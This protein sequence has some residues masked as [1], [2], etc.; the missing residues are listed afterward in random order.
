MCGVRTLVAG[1]I[2]GILVAMK[3]TLLILTGLGASVCAA[4]QGL[5]HDPS[6]D[7]KAKRQTTKD[8]MMRKMSADKTL[9]Y[10]SAAKICTAPPKPVVTETASNT[11]PK[12]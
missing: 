12:Q 5:A 3:R 6:G 10:N 2:I 8:C 11:S 4:G 9:S 7:P 1:R